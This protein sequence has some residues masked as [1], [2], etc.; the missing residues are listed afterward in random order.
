VRVAVLDELGVPAAADERS[1]QRAVVL[2]VL[3]ARADGDRRRHRCD[4]AAAAVHLPDEA[5]D[6]CKPPEPGLVQVVAAAEEAPRLQEEAGREAG[7]AHVR[8]ERGDRAEARAHQH[9]ASSHRRSLGR[10]RQHVGGER[11]RVARRRRVRLV[12]VRRRRHEQRAALGDLAEVDEVVEQAQERRVLDV[13]R[14]VVDDQERQR[15]L[16]IGVRRRPEERA[17]R[18]PEAPARER[19]LAQLARRRLVVERPRG[20]LVARQ[21]EHRLVAERAGGAIRVAG[22]RDDLGRAAAAPQL[23]QILEPV[24]WR[25][26]EPELPAAPLA[27]VDEP[28]RAP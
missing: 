6:P 19:Q 20:R 21:L 18:R 8:V 17:E 2:E 28:P 22:I 11:V 15:L 5:R 27:R 3:L 12:P 4:E 1:V 16:R 9:R 24:D 13:L 7:V 23:E 10:E 25:P 26:R 14:P